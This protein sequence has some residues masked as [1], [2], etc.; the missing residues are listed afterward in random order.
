MTELQSKPLR[1][2]NNRTGAKDRAGQVAEV[3]LI[4]A[5]QSAFRVE[6]E[7]VVYVAVLLSTPTRVP[8]PVEGVSDQLFTP[9][10][11]ESPVTVAV[12]VYEVW[13][14][15]ALI[16]VDEEFEERATFNELPP[17][18]PTRANTTGTAHK[19]IRLQIFTII[20][21]DWPHAST[22]RC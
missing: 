3:A 13:V 9:A 17:P 22:H 4:V 5:V 7:G 11:F 18:Q 21:L 2:T 12:I 15:V 10:F 6:A 16:V 20:S 14:E 1:Y 8:Q 19:S